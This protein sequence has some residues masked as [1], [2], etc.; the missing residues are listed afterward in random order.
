MRAVT[1]ARPAILLPCEDSAYPD[2]EEPNS[3]FTGH[4]DFWN[5]L[6]FTAVVRVGNHWWNGSAW[7]TSQATCTIS[8]YSD[9]NEITEVD[10][11][12]ARTIT[13]KNYYYTFAS[14]WMNNTTVNRLNDP[15]MLVDC[16][17]VSKHNSPLQGQMSFQ[18]LGQI[19]FQNSAPGTSVYNSV[20]FILLDGIDIGWTDLSE[21]IDEDISNTASVYMDYY[22]ETK[23]VMTRSLAMASPN[24]PGFFNN[25][26]V[27]DGGDKW[28]NLTEVIS[29][30]GS[31]ARKP[32]QM[33]ASKLAELYGEG[34]CFVEFSTPIQ[35]DD[36]VYNV[37]FSVVNL[38]ETD[39]KFMPVKREYNF[40]R[41]TMRVKLMRVNINRVNTGVVG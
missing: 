10:K 25:V 37:D 17:G 30:G 38:V 28:H 32:E 20:P 15:Q 18:I 7:V 9:T 2:F 14:P 19:H 6:S 40:V 31:V 11:Y 3:A 5:S 8:L 13:T 29:Q 27:Y 16:N 39:G 26:L 41:E 12:G 36:N 22:S 35:Y 24:V 1:W 34:K 21:Q 23:E 33:L 4:L